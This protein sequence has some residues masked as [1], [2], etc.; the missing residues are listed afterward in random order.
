MQVFHPGRW[1][2]PETHT[3]EEEVSAQKGKEGLEGTKK[4]SLLNL[5][6]SPQPSLFVAHLYNISEPLLLY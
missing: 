3:G 1:Q 2:L 4:K 6:P 5:P